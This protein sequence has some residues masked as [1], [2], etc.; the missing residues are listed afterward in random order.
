MEI[1]LTNDHQTS[2]GPVV[3]SCL[4]SFRREWP[5]ELI[6]Q[7]LEELLKQ[8]IEHYHKWLYFCILQQTNSRQTTTVK[9]S[10]SGILCPFFPIKNAI[11]KV[12][13]VKSSPVS[14]SKVSSE[15][16]DCHRPKQAEYLAGGAIEDGNARI[17]KGL[18]ESRGMGL[19][20]PFR[21]LPSHFHPPK[22][23]KVPTVYSQILNSPIHL[24]AL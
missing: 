21:C 15:M 8:H 24:F 20:I 7:W 9:G 12:E 1:P 3:G 10:R 13:K 2:T 23:K 6:K 11:E 22:L 19:L 16:E 18:S 14:C 5:E 17:H 4:S